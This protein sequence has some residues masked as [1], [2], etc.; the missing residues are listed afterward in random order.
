MGKILTY[1]G[2][3]ASQN[4]RVLEEEC[5]V[6]T[7]DAGEDQIFGGSSLDWTFNL[8]ANEPSCGTGIWSELV[9]GQGTFSNIYDRNSTYY[10]LVTPP[11]DEPHTMSYTLTW[12]ITNSTNSSADSVDLT[13]DYTPE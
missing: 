1:K 7:A 8:D 11:I 9:E 6:T 4:G 10:I 5:I 3:I 13:Y 12:T 2:K